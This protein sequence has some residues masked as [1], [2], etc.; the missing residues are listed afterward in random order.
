MRKARLVPGIPGLR[1]HTGWACTSIARS[2]YVA[3]GTT[4]ALKMSS[5]GRSSMRCRM[6]SPVCD[7][8]L[9]FV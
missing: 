8:G 1:L 5:Q 7:R 6:P 3:G 9:R 4:P 2:V